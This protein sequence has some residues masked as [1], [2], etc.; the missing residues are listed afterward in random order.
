MQGLESGVALDEDLWHGRPAAEALSP[1]EAVS[2]S[3]T[4]DDGDT[5]PLSSFEPVPVGTKPCVEDT[6]N[7]VPELPVRTIEDVTT[8]PEMV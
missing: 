8:V 4:E 5:G 1:D 2:L 7:K 6:G 3:G